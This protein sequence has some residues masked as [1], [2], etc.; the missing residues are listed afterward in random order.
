M[1]T[2]TKYILIASAL[3][4][5]GGGA[6]IVYRKRKQKMDSRSL[7]LIKQLK[8]EVQ[9]P[10]IKFLKYAK[11]KG[12]DLKVVS[13]YRDC[14]EQTALYSQGRTKGG[15]VVT[16]SKCGDSFHNYGLAFDVVPV[17]GGKINWNS[18]QWDLIGAMGKRFG[19]KWGGDFRTF[20]DKPH[21]E[22]SA[23][24]SIASLKKQY[25]FA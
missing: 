5:A 11:S 25:N 7:E 23:N 18:N 19:F 9:A 12:I 10:A 15:Q 8:I 13:G 3:L 16:N 4:I 20:K 17:E 24:T 21:F 2:K 14:Q 1:E 6:Y 22:W